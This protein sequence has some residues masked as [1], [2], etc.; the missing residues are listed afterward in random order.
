MKRSDINPMPE[1]YSQYINLVADIELSEAFEESIR[2]L[3]KLDR[4]LLTQLADR[5][6][7]PGKWTVK[8]IIQHVI[9]W[10]RILTYR[11]LLIA[12]KERT[13]TR[14]IDQMPLAENSNANLRTVD[15]LLEELKTVRFATRSFFKSL[16]D[17]SLLRNG[18]SWE[19]QVSVLAMAFM[20]LGHQVHHFNVIE[21]KYYRLLE[22]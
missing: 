9:D 3:D 18:I 10:E 22:I 5:L 12:R 7:A 21:E 14:S 17:E 15:D 13:A 16:N 20:M 6:Y 11:T 1:Y 19:Y 2:Q 4:D 8:E